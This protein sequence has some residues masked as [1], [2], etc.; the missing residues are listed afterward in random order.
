[1]SPPGLASR[2]RCSALRWAGAAAPGRER[3]SLTLYVPLGGCDARAPTPCA[4]AGRR[5]KSV[6]PVEVTPEKLPSRV[7]CVW[8]VAW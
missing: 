6:F 4:F 8:A 5:E 3:C 2:C 7:P 1:M